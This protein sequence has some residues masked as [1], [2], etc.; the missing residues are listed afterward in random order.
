[1]IIVSRL[2]PLLKVGS[3]NDLAK[4]PVSVNI[5]NSV[6]VFEGKRALGTKK[7][8]V[9]IFHTCVLLAINKL[10][11]IGLFISCLI[12]SRVLGLNL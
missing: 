5:P 9:A 3:I 11:N 4:I 8:M 6:Y 7:S 12:S 2:F 10:V 1:M